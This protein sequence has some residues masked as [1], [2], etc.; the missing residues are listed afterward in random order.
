TSSRE[1]I[2][3]R[4]RDL[5]GGLSGPPL[6]ERA[7]DV[8][9]VAYRAT[10]GTIPIIGVGGV[11]S[12]GDAIE[13]LRSGATLVQIYTSLI[14]GGPALPGRILRDMSDAADRDGWESISEI[15][16]LDA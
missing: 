5:P 16:G 10:N 4:Y 12:G 9:R 15:I 6:R 13:R 8:V 11:S 14:Y 3:E 7:N 2:H 1:G